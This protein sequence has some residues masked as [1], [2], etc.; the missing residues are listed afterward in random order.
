MN[1]FVRIIYFVTNVLAQD[2]AEAM[3]EL[4]D[5]GRGARRPQVLHAP[6]AWEPNQGNSRAP[7][8][9]DVCLLFFFLILSSS[10]TPSACI[11]AFFVCLSLFVLYYINIWLYHPLCIQ[12]VGICGRGRE[13]DRHSLHELLD[14][15]EDTHR[16]V[17]ASLSGLCVWE[18]WWYILARIF[19]CCACIHYCC[20]L[21][22]A[23]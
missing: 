19:S 9:C 4:L 5:L 14:P 21:C 10:A 2:G 7:H 1:F 15:P 8:W 6:R 23:V 20:V 13:E 17:S 16:C 18:Y 3:E 12:G 11:F 22:D